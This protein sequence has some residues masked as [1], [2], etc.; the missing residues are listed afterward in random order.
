MHA[1]AMLE[2]D[3]AAAPAMMSFR[4]VDI[5]N[6]PIRENEGTTTIVRCQTRATVSPLRNLFSLCDLDEFERECEVFASQTV[7]CVQCHFCLCDLFD[8]YN[9]DLTVRA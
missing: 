1:S 9:H 7:V 5:K 8:S 2:T 3:R 6:P 4:C